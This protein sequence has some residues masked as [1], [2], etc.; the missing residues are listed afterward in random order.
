MSISAAMLSFPKPAYHY[1]AQTGLVKYVFTED[2]FITDKTARQ[3]AEYAKHVFVGYP[4][5]VTYIRRQFHRIC[6]EFGIKYKDNEEIFKIARD[7]VDFCKTTGCVEMEPIKRTD[8]EVLA[9]T[10]QTAGYDEKIEKW[11]HM[12]LGYLSKKQENNNFIGDD[13]KSH[14]DLMFNVAV[15]IMTAREVVLYLCG[16]YL[17]I[18][19]IKQALDCIHQIMMNELS[20]EQI[21]ELAALRKETANL[22]KMIQYNVDDVEDLKTFLPSDANRFFMKKPNNVFSKHIH[23]LKKNKQYDPEKYSAVNFVGKPI[24][25]DEEGTEYK[26][27]FNMFTMPLVSTVN[28]INDAELREEIE[29]DYAWETWIVK[30]KDELAKYP[31]EL[32]RYVGIVK[33]DEYIH[34]NPIFR[35]K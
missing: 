28:K 14:N 19:K 8:D 3:N 33:P 22:M 5:I 30:F 25:V 31:E 24:V 35:Y 32:S 13:E 7:Y 10:T 26:P 20:V 34:I 18:E 16:N 15:Y 21:T 23:E 29:D 9:I 4:N 2:P 12:F 27:M 6:H 1:S 17:L 11:L